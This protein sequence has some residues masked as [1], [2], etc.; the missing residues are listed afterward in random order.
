MCNTWKLLK[1]T[2]FCFNLKGKVSVVMECLY[3]YPSQTSV[4]HSG[5]CA[6]DW[7]TVMM[8]LMSPK[9]FVVT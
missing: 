6:M 5:T 3:A 8:E 7:Q 9:K 1:M 4:S 2:N